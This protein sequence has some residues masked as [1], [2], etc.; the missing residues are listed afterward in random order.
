MVAKNGCKKVEWL[1]KMRCKMAKWLQK[2]VAKWQNGCKKW[3]QNGKNIPVS[4]ERT[5]PKWAKIPRSVSRKAKSF[6]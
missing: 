6:P 3:L 1:Q 4:I 5:T 2:M